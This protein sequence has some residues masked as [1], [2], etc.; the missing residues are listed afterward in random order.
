M[1]ATQNH[2]TELQAQQLRRL[3]YLDSE[4]ARL[5]AGLA[6]RILGRSSTA[7]GDVSF[8]VLRESGV[9][10]EAIMAPTGSHAD[11]QVRRKTALL[12]IVEGDVPEHLDATGRAVVLGILAKS[13]GTTELHRVRRLLSGTERAWLDALMRR[14]R[15]QADREAYREEHPNA[16]GSGGRRP[17]AGRPRKE[18][19]RLANGRLKATPAQMQAQRINERLRSRQR[20]ADPVK[21]AKIRNAERARYHAKRAVVLALAVSMTPAA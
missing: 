2:V 17:G 18:G 4:I 20:R 7:P 21:R 9:D 12:R 10:I 16:P 5:P 8:E 6:L 13:Q 11:D 15:L 3:G 14:E 1:F 19:E